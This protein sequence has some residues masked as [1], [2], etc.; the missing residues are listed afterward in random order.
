MYAL[1]EQHRCFAPCVCISLQFPIMKRAAIE[2]YLGINKFV[3]LIIYNKRTAA[4][5]TR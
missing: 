2:R 1:I 3:L 4:P 5:I